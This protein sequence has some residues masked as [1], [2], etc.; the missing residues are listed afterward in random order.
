MINYWRYSAT[1]NDFVIFDGRESEFYLKFSKEK[2]AQICVE[3]KTDGVLFLEASNKYD[4]HMRYLNADGGEVEMCGNGARSI[5]HFASVIL[6]IKSEEKELYTFS[7]Y[8]GVYKSRPER[9]Y[10]LKMTE[11]FDE[12]AIKVS[13]LYPSSF[14]YY[15]NTGVPHS[16]FEVS[17]TSAVDLCSVGPK[18]RFDKRFPNGCNFN[19]F[20]HNEN[21]II[22]RTF[23]RGVENETL[24]C[25]TGATAVVVALV[26]NKGLSG[27]FEVTV[28]GGKLFITCDKDCQNIWLAGSVEVTQKG[29]LT[30]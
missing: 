25:G 30:L 15:V 5:T 19:I 21:K 24:S 8:S 20:S 16:L 29:T 4:F 22:M 27:E 18:V 11:L 10:P 3:Y 7:T 14:S 17:D 13:D 9:N 2:I 6:E 1:G 23:E 26:K 12:G 28:P